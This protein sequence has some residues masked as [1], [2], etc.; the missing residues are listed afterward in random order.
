MATAAT[1][2]CA[3]HSADAQGEK[4]NEILREFFEFLNRVSHL[5]GSDV[6]FFLRRYAKWSRQNQR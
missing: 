6:R 3:P 4:S 1:L 5:L 2:C